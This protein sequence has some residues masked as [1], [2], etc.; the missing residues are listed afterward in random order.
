MRLRAFLFERHR[1]KTALAVAVAASIF[2]MTRGEESRTASAR[3]ISSFLLGPAVR[4]EAYFDSMDALRAENRRLRELAA[5]LYHERER[6][7]QRGRERDRLRRLL[8]LR[9]ESPF[10]FLPCEVI[11]RSSS[12]FHQAVT[13]DRGETDGARAGMAVVGYRGLVGRVTQVFGGSSRVLLVNNKAIAV[14]CL[15]SRSG[16]VGILE[17]ERGNL[18]RLEYVGRE[19][20]VAPGDTLL[21]SGLGQLF[22]EGFPVGIV[23]QVSTEPGNLSRRIGVVSMADLHKIE[24]L[25]IVVSGEGW[26][27]EAAFEELERRGGG[28]E[29]P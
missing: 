20:D 15:D 6:L 19:E 10:S 3:A 17:W 21:T 29:K 24:E 16:V 28:E 26:D 7:V 12:R 8:E 11:A 5:S 1:D 13:V 4:V 23:F 14:S 25:F 18:F 9:E 2:L 27:A 22:P